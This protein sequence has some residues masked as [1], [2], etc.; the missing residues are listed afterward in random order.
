MCGIAGLLR[1]GGDEGTTL[2]QTV[3]GMTA[4]L[5]HRGPDAGDVWTDAAVG[6]SLGH[7]RLSILDLT[8]AGAQPMRSDCGR[9]T[10]TF[11]GEIY[12]HLAI[13]SELEAA[14]AAPNWRG[15]SDTETLLYAVRYWGVKEAL[16]RLNGMFALAIWD[17]RDRVL[18]L[19]RDRFGEKP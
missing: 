18:T 13:R 19:C 11:N 4:A 7:R 10:V 17:A 5:A 14:G 6:I 9:F 15:H 3:I 1:R 16:Q 12:N 8:A 2:R